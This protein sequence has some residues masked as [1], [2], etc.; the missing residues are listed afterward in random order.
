MKEEM[1][2]K[3]KQRSKTIKLN[4]E[5]VKCFSFKCKCAQYSSVWLLLNRPNWI[6]FN[7]QRL[8][9]L[10]YVLIRSN[11]NRTQLITFTL[12]SLTWIKNGSNDLGIMETALIQKSGIIQGKYYYKLNSIFFQL[13]LLMHV[14]INQ[15]SIKARLC[16]NGRKR[17]QNISIS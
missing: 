11:S 7:T 14:W 12:N 2:R 4:W 13:Y 9:N 16:L 1:K 17:E 10:K 6:L 3:A 5:G 8:F 15:L